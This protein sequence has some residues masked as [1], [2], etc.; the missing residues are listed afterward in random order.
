MV[1]SRTDATG[2]SHGHGWGIAV[3]ENHL[4][5]VSREAWDA[6]QNESF[7]DAAARVYSKAVIA[8]VRRAT[9]GAA[10][11]ENTHPFVDGE[12]SFAHNGTIPNFAAI[13]PRM[14]AAMSAAHRT[15][16]TGETDSEHFFR[17]FLSRLHESE[18]SAEDALAASAVDVIGW[19][20]EEDPDARIGLNVLATNGRAL[21]GL[22]W[23]RSLHFAERRGV[24]DCEICRYPHIL[25][26]HSDGYRA[27]VIASEPLTHGETWQ[28]VP[29]GSVFVA[30]GECAPAFRSLGL[31]TEMAVPGPV[32]IRAAPTRTTLIDEFMID[33][34]AL[35]EGLQRLIEVIESGNLP[36]AKR[37][38][39]RIDRISGAHIAFEEAELYPAIGAEASMYDDH[40]EGLAV[41]RQV[42]MMEGDLP[43]G[44]RRRLVREAEG[45]LDH[46]EDC[47][48]LL[49]RVQALAP[50]VQSRLED[51][52]FSWRTR[53]PRWTELSLA[54][55]T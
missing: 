5:A 44:V 15:A 8:H 6:Y 19:C 28:R 12:W 10:R 3:Y 4:P 24:T 39:E 11:I 34:R 53:S 45:M 33:H 14:L 7:R 47:G 40:R 22:R 23:G 50:I 17:L 55:Q 48:V 54:H 16:I 27:L 46:M 13:K 37:E 2:R 41:L 18:A 32:A 51:R 42:T 9:V 43:T 49:F 29:E 21:V 20:R 31:R 52:L 36:A 26:T 25:T 35:A 38:A 1:Q 30:T